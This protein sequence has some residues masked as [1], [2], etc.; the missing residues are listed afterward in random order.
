MRAAADDDMARVESRPVVAPVP[1]RE[2]RAWRP[3]P[4]WPAIASDD[5]Q[6]Q[7]R[8]R[9]V[10]Q[11]GDPYSVWRFGERVEHAV[12]VRDQIAPDVAGGELREAGTPASASSGVTSVDKNATEG[13]DRVALGDGA[14]FEAVAEVVP[15]RT[16]S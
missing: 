2:P 16:H 10:A 1:A 11:L 12:L 7:D 8:E 9:R 14:Q 4:A 13:L 5:R 6:D 3:G 15:L